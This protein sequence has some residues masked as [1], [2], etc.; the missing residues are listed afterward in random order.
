M[1]KKYEAKGKKT[2]KKQ[3]KKEK[4]EKKKKPLELLQGSK[5]I[6]ALLA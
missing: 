1:N 6:F 2:K 3:N 5:R 4:E